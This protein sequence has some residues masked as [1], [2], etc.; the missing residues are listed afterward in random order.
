MLLSFCSLCFSFLHHF[1]FSMEN[2]YLNIL[3]FCFSNTICGLLIVSWLARNII[4]TNGL[5]TTLTWRRKTRKKKNQDD[6]NKMSLLDLPDLTLDCILEKLSPSELCA[7]ACVCSELRDKC[8]CDHLWKKHMEKRWGRLMGDA[9]IKEWKT[10]VATLMACLKNS[11]PSSYRSNAQ[12]WRSRLAANLKPFSWLKTNHG[13]HNG[14]SSS[15]SPIDSVMYWYSNL[16]SGKF[17]FPAQVY[18]R[19]NGHVGFM[20]SCYDAK[21]RYDNRTNTFQAR[22]SAHGRRAAEEN[23]T[24]QRLRP[25]LVETE[26]RDLHVSDC[27]QGLRPGDHFEIQWRRTK[28]FP[29]GWWFGVVGH[30]QNCVGEENCRCVSD[31]NVVMEFR[32]FRPESPWKTTVLNRKDHRETGNE[33]SGFYGGVKKLGT[34]EEVSTWKRL[35]PSQVLD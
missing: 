8:V 6:E 28:E 26:S 16:E 9:A 2:K 20:M 21:V 18:N 10:H 27:L 14:G 29:Y 30:L 12:Q 13:C 24:W 32:Q 23:V 22:Y 7:M 25:A 11:N 1:L 4:Y 17:W 5:S 31:E 15:S 35:W 3:S 33:V 19:E 34:E